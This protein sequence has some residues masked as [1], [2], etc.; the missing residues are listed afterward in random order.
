[1]P[2]P[3]VKE[4]VE[5]LVNTPYRADA[6]NNNRGE[7]VS[8]VKAEIPALANVSSSRWREGVNVI[9]AIQ[10][11]N[12]PRKGTAIATFVNGRFHSGHGHAAFYW[13]YEIDP[14]SNPKERIYIIEQYLHPPTGGVVSRL[15]YNLGK[16][17]NGNYLH[18]SNNGEAFSVIM[19]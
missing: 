17:S 9:Q 12:E 8:L 6:A 5:S 13:R 14:N 3:F 18:R 10:S 15:L 19:L 7:C 4:Y 11:G 1:M 2:G 16:D